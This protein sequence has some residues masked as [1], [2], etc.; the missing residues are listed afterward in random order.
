M[1]RD[2]VLRVRSVLRRDAVE[3][4]MDQEL[5]FHLEREIG[6]NIDRGMS[7]NEATRRAKMDLGGF[8]QV[9]EESR[10]ARGISF[11]ETTI[12]DLRYAFRI[13]RKSS[14]FTTVAVLSLALGVG[15]NTASFQLIDAIRLRTLPVN[16]PSLTP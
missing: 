5:R 12:S 2:F 13:L 15:A 10:D 3:R 6:K 16:T 4:E 8:E 14:G 7:E 9:K 1:L 11:F